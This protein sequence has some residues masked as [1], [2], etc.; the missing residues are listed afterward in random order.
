M[1]IYNDITVFQLAE[2]DQ[3]HSTND[4]IL[5]V[6]TLDVVDN[7]G[8]GFA[9]LSDETLSQ[10]QFTYM[11]PG[12]SFT[13]NGVVYTQV[14]EVDIGQ[15]Q[16][17]G[18]DIS[19]ARIRLSDNS[20]LPVEFF[21]PLQEDASDASTVQAGDIITQQW[22]FADG[23]TN[24]PDEIA[25]ADM[26][27]APNYIVEGTDAGDL[28]D[29]TYADDPQGDMIDNDDGN[30]NS[31]GVGNNDSI[32]AGAGN[33]TVLAGSGDDTIY[34]G[35]GDDVIEGDG[36][37][38][39]V[40]QAGSG[41]SQEFYDSVQKMDA[42]TSIMDLQTWSFNFGNYSGNPH[43]AIESN[44]VMT[45][46]IQT[47][48][49]MI[50]E[51]GQISPDWGSIQINNEPV[52]L[53]A[54]T[55]DT[56]FLFEYSHLTSV[57]FADGT[58]L[59]ETDIRDF[60]VQLYQDL[61]YS[62]VTGA[63]TP[64]IGTMFH[65]DDNGDFIVTYLPHDGLG[66]DNNNAEYINPQGTLVLAALER[67]Y[68]EIT[69]HT[70]E[71][72]SQSSAIYLGREALYSNLGSSGSDADAVV[73]GNDFIDGG[74]GA[75]VIFGNEGSDTIA[76][77][78][79]FGND[80]IEGGED[81]GDS[82]VDVLDI[83]GLTSGAAV[84]LSANGASDVESG[85]VTV[86]GDTATFSEIENIAFTDNGDTV[87]G[88]GGDDDLDLGAGDDIV[89]AGDGDDTIDGGDGD[90]AIAGGDG[91]DVLTGGQGDDSFV[92]DNNGADVINDFGAGNSGET[93]DGDQS[94][95][96][97]VDLSQYYTNKQEL[98]A[99]F[100]DD[101]ILNQSTGDFSDNTLMVAGA[102]LEILGATTSDLNYDTTN[103]PCFVKGTL[104]KCETGV[105]PVE[106]LKQGDMVWT[107]DDGYQA[108]RWI[109]ART[110]NE[111]DLSLNERIR[112][113][114][115][116]KGS[117]GQDMPERDLLVS[118]QHR[119]LVNSRIAKR[120]TNED[121]V[122]VSA[123]HM[124]R[125][126]GIDVVNGMD[127]VMYVHFMFDRHQIVEAE[128]VLSESL[129]AGPQAIRSLLPEARAELLELFPELADISVLGPV[130]ARML[131]SGRQGRKLV[132]RQI[133][134]KKPLIQPNVE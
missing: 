111:A 31:P 20:F 47:E 120:M 118:P 4:S 88:S 108:I 5:G 18:V 34:G 105:K 77:T 107:K 63:N 25:Y 102:S 95:N 53:L 75:D 49:D 51:N 109:G 61:G 52:D 29:G 84:D 90:D 81:D 119:V 16:I 39:Q 110:F 46:P 134:N 21:I 129:Y 54:N 70:L 3:V 128:G 79:S 41:L 123:K 12:Q 133:H 56:R 117:I 40:S 113:I 43:N 66:S 36:E 42:E 59:D 69:S 44:V 93:D 92:F 9:P 57:T 48:V 83:S 7:G 104:I 22:G 64:N 94:N 125:I 126:T 101:G 103:V 50:V 73:P 28:I 99:D 80:T 6:Y 100:L 74:E 27:R 37:T 115:I 58:T 15:I 11:S 85:T 30:P 2:I 17:D 10:S 68:G 65:I 13:I 131:L 122:L 62:H 112:P 26:Y 127:E 67:E 114:R 97:F 121:E 96:D 82:D 60:S 38:S 124:L 116:A 71:D 130:P 89:D 45:N 24:D 55:N 106:Q 35:A 14:W 86:G 19:G 8:N 78:D 23:Q 72:S 87:T 98:D 1:A 91:D 32:L 33:D 76:L 132:Q